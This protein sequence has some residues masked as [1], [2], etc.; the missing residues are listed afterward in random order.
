MKFF[1]RRYLIALVAWLAVLLAIAVVTWIWFTAA[2]AQDGLPGFAVELPGGLGF[3][4][5]IL[6]PPAIFVGFWYWRWGGGERAV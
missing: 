6:G 1:A 4:A 2:S 3:L 5:L